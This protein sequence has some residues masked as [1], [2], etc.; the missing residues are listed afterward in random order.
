MMSWRSANA[1]KLAALEEDTLWVL[2][3]QITDAVTH[4]TNYRNSATHLAEPCDPLIDPRFG[5]Q[6]L[7]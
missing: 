6:W 7:K 1:R 4:Y 2:F 5:K 3:E